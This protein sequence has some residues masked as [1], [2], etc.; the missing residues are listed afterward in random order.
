MNSVLDTR[1]SFLLY[2]RAS[3]ISAGRDFGLWMAVLGVLH[4]IF[5]FVCMATARH[6]TRLVPFP[7]IFNVLNKS[8]QGELLFRAIL[9]WTPESGII[10]HHLHE[11]VRFSECL[12][13]FT[14]CALLSASA[15]WLAYLAITAGIGTLLR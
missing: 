2:V 11:L 8:L 3:T 4:F 6:I 15:A 13:A 10:H 14:T 1:V 12:E 5:Y 7:T 9:V